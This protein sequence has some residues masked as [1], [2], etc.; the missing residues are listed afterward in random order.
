MD[1]DVFGGFLAHLPIV[2]DKELI[3]TVILFIFTNF[4]EIVGIDVMLK[5]IVFVDWV[6]FA[7]SF[8]H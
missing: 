3:L 6:E 8:V 4:F 1:M 5:L 7:N 2:V